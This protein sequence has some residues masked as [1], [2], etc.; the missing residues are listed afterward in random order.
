L[1][2]LLLCSGLPG[3]RDVVF[4]AL[5][6]LHE[7]PV[8]VPLLLVCQ[9]VRTSAG[10]WVDRVL[11]FASINA[12]VS[13]AA[14]RAKELEAEAGEPQAITWEVV[15]EDT[16]IGI[17]LTFPLAHLSRRPDAHGRHMST[18]DF[19]ETGCLPCAFCSS[20]LAD[21]PRSERLELTS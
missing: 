1:A 12:V 4:L 9:R 10:T 14:R 6:Y 13:Y 5:E 21:L 7:L 18:S 17:K 19:L 16:L 2:Q 8:R 20:P 11:T 3:S 15:L